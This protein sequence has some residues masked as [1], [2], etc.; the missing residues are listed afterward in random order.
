MGT[1]DLNRIMLTGRLTVEP[2]MRITA[3][4]DAYTTCYLERACGTTHQASELFRLVAW[5]PPLAE[6]CNDLPPGARI[7]VEGRLQRCSADDAQE[8]ARFPLEIR[9]RRVLRIDADGAAPLAMPVAP[10]PPASPT[11][12]APPPAAAIPTR[13]RPA[14]P[15]A[16][17][18]TVSSLRPSA[19]RVPDQD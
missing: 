1:H 4:G 10:Q 8:C 3:T 11:R 13:R 14:L 12:A 19:L 15:T 7:L 2:D 16:P 18:P 9:I 6:R 5:G 17:R